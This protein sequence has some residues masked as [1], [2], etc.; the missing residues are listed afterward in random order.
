MKRRLVTLVVGSLLAAGGVL[1]S[2]SPALADGR[3]FVP[4][5]TPV[6]KSDFTGS[7]ILRVTQYDAWLPFDCWADAPYGPAERFFRLTGDTG[8]IQAWRVSDQPVV[9][10]C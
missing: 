8:W 10:P 3:G 9:P 7:G 4:A 2:A 1:A 5:Q 6:Y